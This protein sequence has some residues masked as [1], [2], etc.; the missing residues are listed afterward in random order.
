MRYVT[1]IYYLNN[2]AWYPEM[3]GETGIYSSRRQSVDAADKFISPENNTL[4]VFECSPHSWHSFRGTRVRRNSITLWLH[5]DIAAAQ[6][7]WPNHEPVYW[8]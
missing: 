8:S 4:L 7:Q 3:G 6:N 2:D 5:R 1:L